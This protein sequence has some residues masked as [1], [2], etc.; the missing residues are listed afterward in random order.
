MSFAITAY[1]SAGGGDVQITC[2]G[3]I[4]GGS[5]NGLQTIMFTVGG[6]SG[7]DTNGFDTSL[8]NGTWYCV[9][10]GSN[11]VTLRM[12][13]PLS[14]TIN[15]TTSGPTLTEDAGVAVEGFFVDG[16]HVPAAPLNGGG[17]GGFF[18]GGW[19]Q[20]MFLAVQSPYATFVIAPLYPE[21]G[22]LFP[23]GQVNDDDY[24]VVSVVN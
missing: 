21:E 4:T 24:I 20:P 14:D 10:S 15:G 3:G 11:Y 12:F 2:S 16:W 23:T 19:E 17:I 1:Q 9:G 22:Q 5:A 13:M 18:L 7:V 8:L 6:F